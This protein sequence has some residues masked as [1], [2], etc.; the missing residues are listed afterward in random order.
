MR[1]KKP[2]KKAAKKATKPQKLIEGKYTH[3]FLTRLEPEIG[4]KLDELKKELGQKTFNGTLRVIIED[5]QEWYTERKANREEM[6]KL[7]TEIVNKQKL[8]NDL[9]TALKQILK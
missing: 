8:L 9:K 2:T 3:K 4:A 7:T 5:Y 1:T 6:F